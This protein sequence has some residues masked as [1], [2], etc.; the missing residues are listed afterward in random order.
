[1]VRNVHLTVPLA[2]EPFSNKSP[3]KVFSR[4]ISTTAQESSPTEVKRFIPPKAQQSTPT[5]GQQFI[6]PKAQQSIPTNAQH[7][8]PQRPN[9]PFLQMPNDNNPAI[10]LQ[11]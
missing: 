4:F 6:L 5:N 10:I 3:T 8:I 9:S 2:N 11:I 7:F 1:M